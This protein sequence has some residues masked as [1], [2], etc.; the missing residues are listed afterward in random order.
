MEEGIDPPR[1]TRVEWMEVLGDVYR[2]GLADRQRLANLELL[3][4]ISDKMAPFLAR[5]H[6]FG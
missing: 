6:A 3:E 2:A 1:L 5:A 4:Q